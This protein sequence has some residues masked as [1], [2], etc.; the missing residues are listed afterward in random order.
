MYVCVNCSTTTKTENKAMTLNSLHLL[1]TF[2][3]LNNI[4]SLPLK[5][6]LCTGLFL[7]NISQLIFNPLFTILWF[8][9]FK[10]VEIR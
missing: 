3:N 10:R 4:S 7:G 2:Y 6:L 8:V 5:F 9:G 1:R